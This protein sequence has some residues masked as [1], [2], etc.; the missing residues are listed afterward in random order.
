MDYRKF[1][2][3]N[4]KDHLPMTFM[5]K[6]FDRLVGKELYCFLDGFSGYIKI[7][8]APEDQYKITFTLPLWD[9]CIQKHAAWLV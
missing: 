9:I 7:S 8:I 2:S 1:N 4:E 6:M 5:D 3:C